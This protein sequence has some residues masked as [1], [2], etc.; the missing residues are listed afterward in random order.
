MK[1]IILMACALLSAGCLASYEEGGVETVSIGSPSQKKPAPG[2][3]LGCWSSCKLAWKEI[4]L[5]PVP[6]GMEDQFFDVKDGYLQ[7]FRVQSEDGREFVVG[8]DEF[9]GLAD[10]DSISLCTVNRCLEGQ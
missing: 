3:D 9:E 2:R 8:A 10:G 1:R 4:E 5:Q 7:I 6:A